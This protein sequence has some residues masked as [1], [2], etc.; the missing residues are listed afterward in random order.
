MSPKRKRNLR[1]S[2]TV[3]ECNVPSITKALNGYSY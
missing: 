1:G 2:T 3:A